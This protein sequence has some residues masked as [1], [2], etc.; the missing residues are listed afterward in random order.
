MPLAM[1]GAHAKQERAKPQH[2]AR[3]M[4]FKAEP[5]V[6]SGSTRHT[7]PKNIDGLPLS[8]KA[9]RKALQHT[10]EKSRRR[11]GWKQSLKQCAAS[12]QD[13]TETRGKLAAIELAKCRLEEEF[14]ALQDAASKQELADYRDE[15]VVA[16]QEVQK[17]RADLA[18]ARAEAAAAHAKCRLEEEFRAFQDAASKQELADYRDEV[19]VAGQEVQELRGDLAD[20]RAEAAA[21]Q[22]EAARLTVKCDTILNNYRAA[23]DDQRA[24]NQ[25]LADARAEAAAAQQD[26]RQVRVASD[27]ILNNYDVIQSARRAG[28]D[29]LSAA[30][31]CERCMAD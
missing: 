11:N 15:V 2:A 27:T 5:R 16:G 6:S 30:F 12:K 31:R 24:S 29:L 25:A 7:C 8:G 9:R 4:K 10:Y 19:V 13:A 20:A 1:V 23:K 28:Y 18:D 17:L 22:Q 21:A 14:R 26:A 3:S